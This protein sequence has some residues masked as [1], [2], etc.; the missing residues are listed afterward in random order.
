MEG[1]GGTEAKSSDHFGGYVV[2]AKRRGDPLAARS[3]AVGTGDAAHPQRL[4]RTAIELARQ[5][6][7]PLLE[8]AH[9]RI[10]HA[11]LVAPGEAGFFPQNSRRAAR[12]GVGDVSAAVGGRA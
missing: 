7:R 9:R 11:P 1:A 3:L 2:A 5:L 12:D 10:G 8:V 4:G 6:A